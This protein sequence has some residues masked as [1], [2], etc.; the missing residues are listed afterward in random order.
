MIAAA[1]A[2]RAEAFAACRYAIERLKQIAPIWKHEYFEGGEGW[3][4]GAMADPEDDDRPRGGARAG[5]HVTVRLF[6]RLRELAGASELARERA[7]GRD[8][9]GRLDGARRRISGAGAYT[10]GDLV[11][12]ERGVRAD[13][14]GRCG[15]R[16]SRVSAA[17]LGRLNRV[18]RVSLAERQPRSTCG[19]D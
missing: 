13:D 12:G 7:A 9:R 8:S 14:H 5:M 15:R 1:R 19:P 18:Q 2:H 3:I 17:R 16:R 6:A 11:R 10:R 4:E